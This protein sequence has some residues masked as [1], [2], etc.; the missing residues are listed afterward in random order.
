MHRFS[1]FWYMRLPH[2]LQGQ[3]V[4]SQSHGA[5]AYCGGH[6]AAQ[7]A[8]IGPVA[9]KLW[10]VENRPSQLLWPLAYTTACTTVQAVIR[11]ETNII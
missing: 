11:H 6:L 10:V 8:K 9:L 3:N 5:G 2:R 1:E 7:L 4:K